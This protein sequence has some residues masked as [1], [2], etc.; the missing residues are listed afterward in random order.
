MDG[1]DKIN[2]FTNK[3]IGAALKV[4]TTLGPGLLEHTYRRCLAHEIRKFELKVEEEVILD[5]VY[6]DLLVVGAYRLDLVVE[7][8][9]VIEIKATE[10]LHQVHHDQVIT[11]LRIG[12]KPVGLL[13]NFHTDRLTHGLK[14]FVNNL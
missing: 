9:I 11:Y 1:P 2:E 8:S 12:R 13:I 10:K 3:I 6:D 4:H 5:L 7:D 14:R